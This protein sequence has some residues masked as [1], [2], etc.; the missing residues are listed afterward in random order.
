MASASTE[1]SVE[2][3]QPKTETPKA[4]AGAP[5]R[6]LDLGALEVTQF[7]GW[8]D[9]SKL[10]DPATEGK[11]EAILAFL[12]NEIGLEAKRRGNLAEAVRRFLVEKDIV[13]IPSEVRP[14]ITETPP[15]Y[16]AYGYR[17]EQVEVPI[18]GNRAKRVLHGA[19]NVSSG[20][21]ALLITQAWQ[22]EEHREQP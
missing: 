4:P 15:L 6:F 1:T 19:I 14:I 22:Q 21:V 3:S 13:T 20:D 11:D 17:G 18:T 12:E 16:A 7:K 5:T 8:P 2:V 9:L 10:M